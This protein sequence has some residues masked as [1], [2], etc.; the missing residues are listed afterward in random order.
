MEY[1][2]QQ[3]RLIATIF[4]Y[5]PVVFAFVFG[6]VIGSL[7]NVVIYRMPYY[8]S[9]WSP[10]S[11]CT[12]CGK[13]IP[14]YLNVPL[15]SYLALRGKC[16]FCGAK[17][18]SRYFWVELTSGLIYALV[19]MWV[20]SLPSPQGLGIPISSLL[21]L[22]LEGISGWSASLNF[23]T[24]LLMFKGFALGSMLLIL[25]MIDLEHR[26]LPDRITYPGIIIGLVLSPIMVKTGGP[27]FS[28]PPEWWA[29]PLDALIQSVLGLLVGGGVLYAIALIGP[30]GGGDIKLLAMIGAFVGIR[31]IAPAMF[32]GFVAGGIIAVIL[33]ILGKAGRKDFIPFGPFL[34]LGGLLGF[35]WG[36][37][38][39]VAY[40]QS[41][42]P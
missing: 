39:M 34:A 36:Q 38:I 3:D 18:S 20:Y 32:M 26:I 30:M 11:H 15:V 14:W 25:A 10:P 13:E 24:F 2:S 8:R 9:I 27:M 35:F 4:L 31:A 42:A 5:V 33:M 22:N 21:T 41:F 1:L 17:F 12:S 16:K 23:L 6:T 29:G 7:S 19:V 37:N 40:M 28:F